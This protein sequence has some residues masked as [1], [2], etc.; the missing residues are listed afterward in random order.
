[1]SELIPQSD[2]SL[3][4]T[5]KEIE[6]QDYYAWKNPLDEA[7]R[8]VQDNYGP[9]GPERLYAPK[10]P[11][12]E[13]EKLSDTERQQLWV[14]AQII[15]MNKRKQ[16]FSQAAAL[17]ATS[18]ERAQFYDEIL[19]DYVG[20]PKKIGQ[21]REISA[22]NNHTPF[23]DVDFNYDK[24][25]LNAFTHDKII[26][27][28]ETRD[29]AAKSRSQKLFI[30]VANLVTMDIQRLYADDKPQIESLGNPDLRFNEIIPLTSR[31]LQGMEM[32]F[33]GDGEDVLQPYL[34]EF[35]KNQAVAM[36]PHLMMSATDG[37]KYKPEG[38]AEYSKL[39]P[40]EH[41]TEERGVLWALAQAR[42]L[43]VSDRG[44]LI[45]QATQF[46]IEQ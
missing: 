39:R 3:N 15:E 19:C 6:L 14:G 12:W 38:Y 9:C 25:V 4:A 10:K 8:H 13:N 37:W 21:F 41:L 43:P 36:Q 24:G 23:D 30:V 18:H 16:I 5:P 7:R 31:T 33:M 2:A 28:R 45:S 35:S 32:H 42:G 22:Q 46:E 11:L 17:I 27:V 44:A 34:Q 26:H 40:I 29:P 20:D 1:M